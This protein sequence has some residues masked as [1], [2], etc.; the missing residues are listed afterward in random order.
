[1][2]RQTTAQAGR[3]SVSFGPKK[4]YLVV[5]NAASAMAWATILGRVVSV[6]SYKG[7]SFVPL[8]VDSFARTTQ[9]FAIMEIIHA[10]TGISCPIRT[11][12]TLSGRP[13]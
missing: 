11:Q 7:A 8:A 5:Y 4:G 9:T 13:A 1:M 3:Q 2:A 12:H 6:L 10:L